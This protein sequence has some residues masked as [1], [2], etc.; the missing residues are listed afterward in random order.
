M[1]TAFPNTGHLEFT[2]GGDDSLISYVFRVL[3]PPSIQVV[4]RP[5]TDY[6]LSSSHASRSE[7]DSNS[8]VE[9]SSATRTTTPPSEAINIEEEEEEEEEEPHRGV[10]MATRDADAAAIAAITHALAK[11][12]QQETEDE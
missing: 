1:I 8:E 11:V 5:R 6:Q 12:P 2:L 7:S 10:A 4:I 9:P 3:P